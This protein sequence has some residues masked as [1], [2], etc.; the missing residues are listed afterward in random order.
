MKRLKLL[1]AAF[2]IATT[3]LVSGCF[4]GSDLEMTDSPSLRTFQG[5]LDELA[6][7]I[8]G[9]D[10]THVI[11]TDAKERVY[12]R[13]ALFDLDD[14]IGDRVRVYGA[15]SEEEVS[16][17]PVNVVTVDKV[18]ILAESGSEAELDKVYSSSKSGLKFG[19]SSELFSLSDQDG[20]VSLVSKDGKGSISIKDFK[21][22]FELDSESY[23]SLNY[24]S[25]DFSSSSVGVAGLSAKVAEAANGSTTVIVSREGHFYDFTLKNPSNN[26]GVDSAFDEILDT[27]Q[28]ISID[29]K[30][31]DNNEEADNSDNE[32]NDQTNDDNDSQVD[33]VN[34]NDKPVSG[35][36]F[37]GIIAGF[38]SKSSS[39]I[40]DFDSP[41]SY[42]F[43]D[44]GYFYVIYGDEGG[45][46]RAL[47]QYS[48]E[49]NFS[50]IAKFKRGAVK[51]WD[52]VSGDNVAYNR[53]LTLVLVGENGATEV[54]LEQGYRYLESL[55][56]GFSLQYPMSWYYSRGG[57]TYRF[58][59]KPIGEGDVRVL[60]ELYEGNYSAING[61]QLNSRV[62]S[63][64]GTTF[65]V[66]LGDDVY[67]ISGGASYS[68]QMET[69][70]RTMVPIED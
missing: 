13:S 34:S 70:A 61:N 67:K 36:S 11:V 40:S 9:L 6:S 14:Y 64:G 62:K 42:S 35:S 65:Y 19:Y 66:N 32:E 59:D 10:V 27:V 3:F 63:V 16:G 15:Y 8:R 7:K 33:D 60:V 24:G 57:N 18:D 51:D 49:S 53:P 17:K 4:G 44:N 2:I 58:S 37:D 56:L 69:M 23:I 39:L 1:S 22:S 55:P 29:E 50:V 68:G 43:T 20:S 30:E 31:E 26:D 45:S 25:L 47:V 12:L 41:V 38:G 21:T 46:D 54:T 52:L 48:G 5:E 28:F